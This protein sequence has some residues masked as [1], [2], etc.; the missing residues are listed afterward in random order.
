MTFSKETGCSSSPGKRQND[1][2]RIETKNSVKAYGEERRIKHDDSYATARTWMEDRAQR[3]SVVAS[4]GQLAFEERSSL[5]PVRRRSPWIRAWRGLHD[6]GGT[7]GSCQSAGNVCQLPGGSLRDRDSTVVVDRWL[8][9]NWRFWGG[10][11]RSYNLW[12]RNSSE[13][14][15]KMMRQLLDA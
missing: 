7:G 10:I 9:T 12:Q 11:G 8:N 6:R 15:S 1:S 3:F 13:D 5:F 14:C 2:K 4:E